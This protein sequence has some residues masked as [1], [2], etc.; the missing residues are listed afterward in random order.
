[1]A[2]DTG[3]LFGGLKKL[4]F[5]E[6]FTDQASEPVSGDSGAGQPVSVPHVNTDSVFSADK[7]VASG[8]A[9]GMKAKAYQLLE[10]INQ[11]GVDFLEVWNASEE[12]GGINPQTVKATFSALKYADKTLTKD[13]LLTTGE[14][15]CTQLQKA[16]DSDLQKKATERQQLED[17]KAAERKQL[18]T[19]ISAVEAQLK[20]LQQSLGEKQAQLTTL[21]ASYEPKLRDLDEKISAGKATIDAMIREMQ[22]L[23]SI[24]KKEL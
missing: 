21:D 19:D 3:G 9:A 13:K 18:A 6:G 22:Q 15:Y 11:P 16:I 1:M 5:K 7:T 20:A 2:N 4:L 10:S 17:R 24:A 14:Y 12:A 8:N 23:I